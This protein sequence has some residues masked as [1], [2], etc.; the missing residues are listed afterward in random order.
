MADL[1]EKLHSVTVVFEACV[2]N[3]V[4]LID[5]LYSSGKIWISYTRYLL[6]KFISL[7]NKSGTQVALG[8]GSVKNAEFKWFRQQ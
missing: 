8:N 7:Y 1:V 4:C 6:T 3:H 5:S 2:S